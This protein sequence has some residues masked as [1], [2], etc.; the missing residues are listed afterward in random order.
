MDDRQYRHSHEL[1]SKYIL[2]DLFQV[3]AHN[4]DRS[5]Q[6]TSEYDGMNL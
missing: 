1:Q 5:N 4:L 3:A 2:M 6:Q